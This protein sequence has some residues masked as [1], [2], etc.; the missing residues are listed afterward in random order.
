MS[1]RAR[2]AVPVARG[3]RGLRVSRRHSMVVTPDHRQM[4]AWALDRK[5]SSRWTGPFFNTGHRN[6]IFSSFYF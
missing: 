6:N 2:V 4:S 5:L 3:P 1:I